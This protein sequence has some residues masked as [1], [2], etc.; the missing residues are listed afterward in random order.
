MTVND[1]NTGGVHLAFFFICHTTTQLL[2]HKRRIRYNTTTPDRTVSHPVQ[3]K[4]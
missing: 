2:T 4:R 3:L 1:E